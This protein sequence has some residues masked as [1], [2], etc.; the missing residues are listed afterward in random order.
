ME[1]IIDHWFEA[2]TTGLLAVIAINTVD[3]KWN[4]S[5]IVEQL[6]DIIRSFSSLAKRDTASK[7]TQPI[8]FHPP[9]GGHSG[10]NNG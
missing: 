3:R 9:S 8:E 10:K 6:N 2:A 5:T 1:W 4:N 7:Q